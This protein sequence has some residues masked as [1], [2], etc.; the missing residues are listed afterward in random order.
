LSVRVTPDGSV[1]P[2]ARDIAGLGVP[3]VVTLKVNEV[4][5]GTV[6]LAELVKAGGDVTV[7]VKAWV[8]FGLTPF[9]AW[10][11]KV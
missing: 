2:E 5:A 6:S 7:R 3:V 1:E 11:V 8:A 4:P 10:I 9:A